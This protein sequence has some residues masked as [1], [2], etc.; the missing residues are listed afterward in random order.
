MQV[1]L[2]RLLHH[3]EVINKCILDRII[4]EQRHSPVAGACEIPGLM[5]AFETLEFAANR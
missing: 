2:Q 1:K 4:V 5:Q 3:R